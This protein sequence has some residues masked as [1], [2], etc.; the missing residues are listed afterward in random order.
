MPWAPSFRPERAAGARRE[1]P[2]ENPCSTPPCTYSDDG[3]RTSDVGP[4]KPCSTPPPL[5]SARLTY[6]PGGEWAGDAG[7]HGEQAEPGDPGLLHGKTSTGGASLVIPWAPSFR[8]ERAAG[9][10][11]EE[12]PENPCSTSPCTYSDD[13]RRTSDVGPCKPCSTPQ[14][15]SPKPPQNEGD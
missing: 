11:R 5:R 14:H 9:A 7:V 6:S 8:P 13:G 2:P 1:E 3:R 10:R 12:P 4:C 15:G